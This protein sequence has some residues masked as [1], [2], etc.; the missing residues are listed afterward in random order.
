MCS[1][2]ASVCRG[3]KAMG[4][5]SGGSGVDM[6][7]CVSGLE[8]VCTPAILHSP[9]NQHCHRRHDYLDLA[10]VQEKFRLQEPAEGVLVEDI[11]P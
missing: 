3:G 7:V 10:G 5:G 1:T 9:A 6:C 11:A 4:G 2:H 8:I